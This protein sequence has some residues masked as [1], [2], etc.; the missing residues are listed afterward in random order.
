MITIE[1]LKKE[2]NKLKDKPKFEKQLE[3]SSLL[4][5]YFASKNIQPI[6]VGGLSVEIY[7][8]DDYHTHDIDFV[9]EGWDLFNEVLL[10]LGFDKVQRV[11][12]HKDF[13][14]AVEVP[15]SQLE[16]SKEH[17]Y[18]LT[19]PS[20]RKIYVIGVED[21]IIHRVE[22]V[23]FKNYPKEDEDYE[24]AYRMFYIHK[25]NIDMHYLIKKANES[26]IFHLIEG[27]L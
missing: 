12:Y 17:V 25:D 4:T 21:I 22:G 9:S 27:W 15:S 18:E 5:E 19:L 16:G 1:E 8:R 6:I 7:T 11:W 14:I 3:F 10:S 13:E 24:W 26:N 2:F 23:S 20:G